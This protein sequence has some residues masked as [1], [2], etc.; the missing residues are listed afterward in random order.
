MLVFGYS[1]H[2]YSASSNPFQE[3]QSESMAYQHLI[4][5]NGDESVKIDRLVLSLLLIIWIIKKLFC[6]V[7]FLLN[8]L[9]NNIY[10]VE[11]TVFCGKA[12]K[13]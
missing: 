6:W 2:L 11:L 4:S 7:K 5:W 3:Q 10:Y 1:C 13:C 8:V 9:L 12:I